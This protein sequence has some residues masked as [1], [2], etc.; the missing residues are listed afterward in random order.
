[1]PLPDSASQEEIDAAI[2]AGEISVYDGMLYENSVPWEERDGALW[3]DSGITGEAFGEMTD[4]W[5][6]ATD[7][8]GFFNFMTLRFVKSE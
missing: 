8:N 4:S 1:M 3:F 2:A 6:K 5:V 7:D